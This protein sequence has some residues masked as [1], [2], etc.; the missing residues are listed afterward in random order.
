M[1]DINK[2]CASKVLRFLKIANLLPCWVEYIESKRYNTRY[3]EHHYERH[4]SNKK[5]LIDVFGHTN[6]T[7]F[8]RINYGIKTKDN[9]YAY[10]IFTEFLN[11]LEKNKKIE[12]EN[13]VKENFIRKK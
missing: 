11:L 4:W 5:K 10:E 3:I 8:L 7:S 1:L 13:F 9:F 12:A 6:F 2:E